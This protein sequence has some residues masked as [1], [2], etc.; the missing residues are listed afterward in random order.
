MGCNAVIHPQ[1]M[2]DTA[3]ATD[4]GS[5]RLK[6][7]LRTKKKY[8]QS[9]RVIQQMLLR[10]LKLLL[11]QPAE[12]T[13]HPRRH[14]GLASQQRIVLRDGMWAFGHTSNKDYIMNF[15]MCSGHC[16][17]TV[18]PGYPI[19]GRTPDLVW[20]VSQSHQEFIPNGEETL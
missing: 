9:N 2:D 10:P 12:P 13:K 15:F 5:S 6:D 11:K 8:Q 20:P 1:T 18:V 19:T 16:T 17:S 7:A 3:N 14:M 4:Q